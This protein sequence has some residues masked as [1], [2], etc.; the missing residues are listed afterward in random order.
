MNASS[1]NTTSGTALNALNLNGRILYELCAGNTVT[2]VMAATKDHMHPLQLLVM[3]CVVVTIFASVNR[4][5]ILIR[6]C[7]V[8]CC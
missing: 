6:K 2:D 7:V 1:A 5:R 3:A 8:C 4:M